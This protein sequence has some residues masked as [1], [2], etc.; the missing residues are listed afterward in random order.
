MFHLPPSTFLPTTHHQVPDDVPT[1][2]LPD[3][4]RR[5]DLVCAVL[6]RL[7]GARIR[8]LRRHHPAVGGG[9][10]FPY[11]DSTGPRQLGVA[12]AIRAELAEFLFSRRGYEDIL[13][14]RRSESAAVG[15]GSPLQKRQRRGVLAERRTQNGHGR[16]RLG[17]LCMARQLGGAQVGGPHDRTSRFFKSR[18]G[19]TSAT[20]RAMSGSWGSRSLKICS[21][22]RG[23][24]EKKMYIHAAMFCYSFPLNLSIT[25]TKHSDILD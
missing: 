14:G 17:G 8:V 18:P 19:R 25:I 4:P 22:C 15:E 24:M 5:H 16:R 13:M 3:R 9:H 10:R 7:P 20:G 21:V 23:G 1:P 12:S 11:F 2:H 6:A